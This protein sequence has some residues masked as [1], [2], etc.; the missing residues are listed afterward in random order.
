MED[1]NKIWLQQNKSIGK[2]LRWQKIKSI[3]KGLWRG[4][5]ALCASVLLFLI[6]RGLQVW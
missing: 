5:V 3:G 2:E 4:V 6:G 1:F